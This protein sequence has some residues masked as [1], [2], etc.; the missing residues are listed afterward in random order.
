[1]TSSSTSYHGGF[2]AGDRYDSWDEAPPPPRRGLGSVVTTAIWTACSLGAFVGAIAWAY[3]LGSR[4][5]SDVPAFRDPSYEWKT[6]PGDAGGWRAP[7]QDSAAYAPFGRS[8]ELL[9]PSATLGPQ[10]ERP[11]ESDLAAAARRVERGEAPPADARSNIDSASFSAVMRDEASRA[12]P[13]IRRAAIDLDAQP[14][15]MRGA[16]ER[17]AARPDFP[18]NV[19]K[20]SETPPPN[21][22]AYRPAGAQA[23]GETAASLGATETNLPPE[24][25]P[26]AVQDAAGPAPAALVETP[27]PTAP[28]SPAE[29]AARDLRAAAATVSNAE[30]QLVAL[31]SATAVEKRWAELQAAHADLL[32]SHA[33]RI[34]PVNIGQTKLYRLRVTGFAD[35]AAANAL[36]GRL[37]AK[38]VECFTTSR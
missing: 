36:C 11:P 30:L 33:M 8:R 37:Q 35:R 2:D 5:P 18:P 21:A 4:N 24:A 25:D 20:N 13:L 19:G 17:V 12:D 3:D 38:G 15:L 31:D 29:M 10:P 14:P 32:G 16:D 23:G 27:A 6:A 34:Q 1:M 22:V 26:P 9:D 28:P 7:D